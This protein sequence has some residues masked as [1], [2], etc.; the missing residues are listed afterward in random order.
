M[1]KEIR[2]S[3]SG[4]F[5]TEAVKGLIK[6]ENYSLGEAATRLVVSKSLAGSI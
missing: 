4:E 6:E 3:Y 2:R 1:S 5:K